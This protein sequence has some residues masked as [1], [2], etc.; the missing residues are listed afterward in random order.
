MIYFKTDDDNLFID[1]LTY[2]KQAEFT[3]VKVNYDLASEKDF[4]NGE[5]NIETEHEKMFKEQGIK[6]KALIAIKIQKSDKII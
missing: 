6:I 5:E 1:S 4:W 2:F 3:L